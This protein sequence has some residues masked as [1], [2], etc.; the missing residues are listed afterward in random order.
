MAPDSLR[1]ISFFQTS[2]ETTLIH[3]NIISNIFFAHHTMDTIIDPTNSLHIS[4]FATILMAIALC[5]YTYFYVK[6]QDSINQEQNHIKPLT[7]DSGRKYILFVGDAD[8]SRI[9]FDYAVEEDGRLQLYQENGNK[10]NSVGTC[11]NNI[12]TDIGLSE[13]EFIQ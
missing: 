7:G 6:A 12:E 1:F 11:D 10:T 5:V 9:L 13:N 8:S 4:V 3:D 2:P